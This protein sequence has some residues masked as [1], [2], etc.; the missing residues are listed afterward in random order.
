MLD[1]SPTSDEGSGSPSFS[2]ACLRL[3]WPDWFPPVYVHSPYGFLNHNR[4][5]YFKDQKVERAKAGGSNL[6][7][8]Q[9]AFGAAEDAMERYMR[10]DSLASIRSLLSGRLTYVVAPVKP[11][12]PNGNVLASYFAST[13]ARELELIRLKG[14]FQKPRRKR[15]KTKEFLP[16]FANPV[17]FYFDPEGDAQNIVREGVDFIL[18]DDVLTYGGTFAGLRGFIENHG[19]RVICMTA[20]AGMPDGFNRDLAKSL[21]PNQLARYDQSIFGNPPGEFQLALS[22]KLLKEI[23]TFRNGIFSGFFEELLGYGPNCFTEREARALLS[24]TERYGSRFSLDAF[25]KRIVHAQRT[26][27][28]N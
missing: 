27:N 1:E 25:R 26:A 16:R 6:A 11:S 28:G 8:L 9:D 5:R 15:D 19:G 4:Y 17:E 18:A 12:Y 14:I 21:S 10:Y 13:I 24:Q 3:P 20:L 22:S 23:E 2:E 7:E